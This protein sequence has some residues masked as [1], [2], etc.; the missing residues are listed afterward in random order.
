M[1]KIS[2][3]VYLKKDSQEKEDMLYKMVYVK[4]IQK[5]SIKNFTVLIMLVKL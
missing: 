1:I 5:D 4:V 2:W 3:F